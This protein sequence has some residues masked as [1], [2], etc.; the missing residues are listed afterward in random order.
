M[1]KRRPICP[2]FSVNPGGREWEIELI[3]EIVYDLKE[4]FHLRE[5]R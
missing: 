5:T 2:S 1:L 3:H 4:N